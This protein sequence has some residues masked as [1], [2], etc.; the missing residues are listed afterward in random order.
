MELLEFIVILLLHTNIKT[1]N[2][3]TSNIYDFFFTTFIIFIHFY[4]LFLG[5]DKD[6]VFGCSLMTDF[7]NNNEIKEG[8]KLLLN[9][10]I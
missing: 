6:N 9:L 2:R 3:I 8:I 4:F 10:V 5:K 1:C 7:R